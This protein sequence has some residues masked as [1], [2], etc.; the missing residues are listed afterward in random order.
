[1]V[2]SLLHVGGILSTSI[3]PFDMSGF[4][5]LEDGDGLPVDDKLPIL[6]LDC[7]VELAI[8]RVIVEHIDH[9]HEVNKGVIDDNNIHF[10]R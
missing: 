5:L 2:S 8:G 7:A 9:V 1:M 10:P 6:S 3:S 4:L